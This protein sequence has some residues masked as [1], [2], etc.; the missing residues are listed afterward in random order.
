MND[1]MVLDCTL[2]DGGYLINGMFGYETIKGMIQRLTNAQVDIVECGFLKDQPHIKDSSSFSHIDEVIEYL[3]K[4]RNGKTSYVLLADYS[5]YKADNLKEYDGSSIDGIRECFQ[6]H[7]RKDAMRVSRIM[8]E[9]GYKVYIQPVDIMGYS[10]IELLELISWVNELEPYC[11]SMV[12]TFGSMYMDDLQ[13]LYSIVHYNLDRNIKMGFHSHNNMQLSFALTQEFVKLSFG[14]RQIIVDGTICGMGRGAGNTNTELIIDYLNRKLG[15]NYDLDVLFDIVDVYMISIMQRCKWGYSIPNFIAGINNAHV[16]NITYLIDKH[17]IDAKNMRKII[18]KINPIIRKKYDYDNLENIYIEHFN[19]N[20]D[21]EN[22][23]KYLKDKLQNEKILLI[24]PG[25]SINLERDKI[26]EYIKKEKPKLISINGIYQK[27]NPDYAFFSNFRRLEFCKENRIDLYNT[28]KKII[29]SNVLKEEGT[30]SFV[31]NYNNYIKQGW[32]HFDNSSI[33]LL[34]LL[35]KI[36]VKNIV[37][38][39]LDGYNLDDNDN[40]SEEGLRLVREKET[41]ELLNQEI[42]EMLE[43]IINHLPKGVNISFITNSYYNNPFMI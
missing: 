6:K 3:P 13:R 9:K 24:A 25:K 18:E 5:R 16:H 1:I 42:A 22:T 8:K 7:E 23:I 10:D 26:K 41:Y 29:T 14:Q 40:Y 43:D 4:E 19:R 31:V 34:R 30:N 36:G 15:Y 12:D 28:T 35:L 20:V 32:V 17:N 37:I 33:M 11:F 38:A 27:Y 21:D 39:G 2:R